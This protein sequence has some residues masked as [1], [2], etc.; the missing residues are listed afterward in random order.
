MS[1]QLMNSIEIALIGAAKSVLGPKLTLK[2]KSWISTDTLNAIHQ[3]HSLRKEYGSRSLEYRLTKLNIKKLCK[4]DKESWIKNEHKKLG[5]LPLNQQYYNV[6]KNLKLSLTK[7]IK[8]WEMKSPSGKILTSVDDIL[9]NWAKFYENLYFSHRKSFVLLAEYNDDPIPP[10][11]LNELEYAIKKL[12]NN[13]APGPDNI[14]AEMLKAGGEFLTNNLLKV[15]NLLIV[16][17]QP[18]PEQLTI[19]DIIVIFKKGDLLDCCN[20]R[21]ICLL[22]V[23]YKLIMMV[24]YNRISSDLQKALPKT[25][26]AYQKGRSITEQIQIIQQ[27]IEKLNEFNLRGVICFIDFTKAFDI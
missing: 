27:T 7:N 1:Q 18:T 19:V 16:D 9:E 14:T 15:A 10:V 24:I 25:Q 5:N 11:M 12:K 6:M 23:V 26:A 20:Y 17:H 8:G 13:K 4:I 3:K 2:N 21:P 22:S